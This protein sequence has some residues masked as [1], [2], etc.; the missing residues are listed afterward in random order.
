MDVIIWFALFSKL[1]FWFT[2][3]LLLCI[4]PCSLQVATSAGG[5]VALQ[6]NAA[7]Q[8][9]N[10]VLTNLAGVQP[11]AAELA[12]AGGTVPILTDCSQ[13]ASQ[14]SQPIT[15]FGHQLLLQPQFAFGPGN[16]LP[17]LDAA[18]NNIAGDI[19]ANP[20][21]YG[22]QLPAGTDLSQLG[23]PAAAGG[24]LP[25]SPADPQLLQADKKK[26]GKKKGQVNAAAAAAAGT[27][28]SAGLAAGI[29]ATAGLLDTGGYTGHYVGNTFTQAATTGYASTAGQQQAGQQVAA[30]QPGQAA[31]G[32][33]VDLD[34]E[35]DSNHDTALT[36]AC[37]GGHEELVNLLLSRGADIEHRDKKGFTPLIL[38]ATAGHDKVSSLRFNVMQIR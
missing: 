15:N 21:A 3:L 33:V 16:G 5:Q 37:A 26:S 20:A 10:G 29:Q 17:V 18:G 12:A 30:G 19:A 34:S 25:G 38:A 7:L 28:V 1:Y 6:Y 4:T 22:L 8:A 31:A 27:S 23:F 2:Y 11:T 36:L 24:Q 14:P 9:T 13:H 35:T 32:P